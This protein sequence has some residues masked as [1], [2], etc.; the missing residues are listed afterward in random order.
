MRRCVQRRTPFLQYCLLTETGFY[1]KFLG[2]EEMMIDHEQSRQKSYELLERICYS[3]REGN[4]VQ[5]VRAV[6]E[7]NE[8]GMP[9]L[10]EHELDE[11]KYDLVQQKTLALHT[12]REIGVPDLLLDEAHSK[13]TSR[14]FAAADVTECRSL[15]VEMAECFCR[16][17]DLKTIHSYSVLIQ[18][19]VVAVDTDLSRPLTLQYFSN[20]L[21]VN[22]SY[23]SGLF[24]REVGVTLTEYVTSRRI[25]YAADQLQT[26]QLPIKT[27]AKK[28]GIA[29]VQYFSRV[30]KRRTG[31]TP[32][33][34]RRNKK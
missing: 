19:V 9:G 10:L 21:N 13:Y 26:T 17:N 18:K 7:R 15:A 12:L 29:D 11:W 28:A 5:A 25:A 1:S 14:I 24:R 20:L 6:K 8:L 27:I 32:S 30:F 23:L 16:M 33:Q 4:E 31:Q 34:Y 22:S 2:A 3:I